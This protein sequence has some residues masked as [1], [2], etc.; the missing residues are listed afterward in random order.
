MRCV[1]RSSANK[2]F[3]VDLAQRWVHASV[4][5]DH[6][7]AHAHAWFIGSHLVGGMLA[8]VV[9]PLWLAVNQ[10]ITAFQ[11]GV[12]VWLVAPIGLAALVSRTARLDWG[13]YGSIL[14]FSGFVAWFGI[15]TGGLSSAAI[16]WFCLIP[17]ESAL[18]GGRKTVLVGLAAAL[19]GYTAVIIAQF[20]QPQY[21]A[22]V[23][24]TNNQ[25]T[26]HYLVFAALIY[27]SIL[28][29]RV[30]RRRRHSSAKVTT[31]EGKF[32]LLA[33]NSTD[34][35]TLHL[36]NGDTQFASSA[37]HSLLNCEPASLNGDGFF[38]RVHLHDRVAYKTALSD[39][40]RTG[41]EVSVAF[42]V[43][44]S[45][46]SSDEG[47][48]TL[49]LETRC[50]KIFDPVTGVV[51]IVAVSRDISAIKETEAELN[52]QRSEAERSNEAK[53]RFLAN[54]SHELRT[55]LNAIIGFSD[56]LKQDLFGKFEYEKHSEYANL[57][58][59]SGHHLLNLVNDI[60]DISKI[61]AGRYE[62]CPE[63]FD[64][65]ILVSKTCAMLSP[66]AMDQKVTISNTVSND[67]PELNADSRACRQ[68]L[69]NLLSNAVK[70]S[71][72]GATVSVSAKT[73]GNALRFSV[74]DQGIGIKKEYLE[75]IGQP[76][77][78]VEN[79]IT[80]NFEGT[81]LGLF[82]VKGLVELHHGQFSI[83][84]EPGKGTE[85]TISLPMESTRSR[86]VP[87]DENQTLVHLH[88]DKKPAIPQ[89]NRS[90]HYA[91]LQAKS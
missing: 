35:I 64:F 10:A 11:A 19:A 37:S 80:R 3:L 24:G 32:K 68:I 48:K 70:F 7:R 82:L 2:G 58:N 17:V 90:N 81:G 52:Q 89:A 60:L 61:E 87:S 54:M 83:E 26:Y 39:A 85:V 29:F 67:L 47:Q 18:F 12:F 77:F 55:P 8:L 56:I 44:L 16:L 74:K 6:S 79:N 75:V 38:N 21:I 31:E 66:Q 9:F 63:P 42:R 43:H 73:V 13:V 22:Q 62:I 50:R 15:L 36:E 14:T 76:F 53:S 72:Q 33:D 4:I 23:L 59:D 51:E 46:K 28:A 84:S 40:V 57:I 91:R 30:D 88:E 69:I 45:P 1:L 34:L 49:W 41:G 5:D 65:S 71:H 86:P 78:Q 20:A 25:L 27:G